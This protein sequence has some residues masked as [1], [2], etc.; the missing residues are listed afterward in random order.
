MIL[1]N[2]KLNKFFYV[3]FLVRVFNYINKRVY[4]YKYGGVDNDRDDDDIDNGGG[5]FC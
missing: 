1:W 5:D 2:N 3:L 4:N